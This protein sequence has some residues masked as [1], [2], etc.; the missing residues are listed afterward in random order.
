M[1]RLFSATMILGSILVFTLNQA[2]E[3]KPDPDPDDSDNT[4][5]T[6]TRPVMNTGTS[7]SFDSGSDVEN[8][9]FEDPFS[10]VKLNDPAALALVPEK[11]SG[12]KKNTGEW[13]ENTY[14][15][16]FE[17]K[18]EDFTLVKGQE[19]N[20]IFFKYVEF[21]ER[22]NDTW[23]LIGGSPLT[24]VTNEM[25]ITTT[26]DIQTDSIFLAD[27][28]SLADADGVPY[29]N[30][31]DTLFFSADTILFNDSLWIQ[32]TYLYTDTLSFSVDT[33][34]VEK[35]TQYQ[36]TLLNVK[37]GDLYDVGYCLAYD[38]WLG[39]LSG[40]FQ[41]ISDENML[42]F[43]GCDPA[44]ICKLDLDEL[45]I[46]S[47]TLPYET[48]AA[49]CV[50]DGKIFFF[51]Y[52][53]YPKAFCFVP[54]QG[55]ITKSNIGPAP[56]IGSVLYGEMGP[57]IWI[58]GQQGNIQTPEGKYIGEGIYSMFT[59]RIEN[60]SMVFTPQLMNTELMRDQVGS[61]FSSSVGDYL[62][63]S[64][65]SQDGKWFF[66]HTD[67][68]AW[69]YNEETKTIRVFDYKE[70][71]HEVLYNL[72]SNGRS[73]HVSLFNNSI[74]KLDLSGP[75]L[76]EFFEISDMEIKDFQVGH[77]HNIF[78]SGM[79]FSDLNDVT[80]EYDGE[81]G[82]KVNEWVEENAPPESSISYITQIL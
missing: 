39:K 5:I 33:S 66:Y 41:Y 80:Y 48:D 16:L 64:L 30:I 37:S 25:E 44:Q 57:Y 71:D 18:G 72:K 55:L 54:G 6:D 56:D 19:G 50:V 21:I 49:W 68:T 9:G 75:S 26:Y 45:S 42:Y 77:K 17:S 10:G 81:T 70:Y 12:S 23:Q 8:V 32:L 2:C 29:Q 13:D 51:A 28:I 34:Y 59:L 40:P 58:R 79:R 31:G 47:F 3:E 4:V 78:I 76:S 73:T 74:Y 43:K 53:Q 24:L 36:T 62:Q 60:D 65:C 61:Y 69:N 46:E 63:A 38:K 20:D 11:K 82:Q 35:S 1:K 7:S 67:R 15:R 14:F 52:G 27:T 22:I